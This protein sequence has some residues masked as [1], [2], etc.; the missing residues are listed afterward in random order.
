MYGHRFALPIVP[1]EDGLDLHLLSQAQHPAPFAQGV[2]LAPG[3]LTHLLTLAATL[4]LL[5]NI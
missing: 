4:H 2:E 1:R 5:Q 3:E